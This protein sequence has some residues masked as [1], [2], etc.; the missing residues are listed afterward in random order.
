MIARTLTVGKAKKAGNMMMPMHGSDSMRTA[1]KVKRKRSLFYQEP[2]DQIPSNIVIKG[3]TMSP[4]KD[5]ER[6]YYSTTK[7]NRSEVVHDF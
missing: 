6:Q 4:A 5:S 1:K 3:L 7:K 2:C